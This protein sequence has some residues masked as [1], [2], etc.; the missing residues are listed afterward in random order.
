MSRGQ[1]VLQNIA[2]KYLTGYFADSL[3]R[4]VEGSAQDTLSIRIENGNLSDHKHYPTLGLDECVRMLHC[5]GIYLGGG[6]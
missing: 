6:D 5:N 4:I 1:G 2:F 3:P